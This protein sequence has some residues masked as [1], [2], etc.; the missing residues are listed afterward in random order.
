[1]ALNQIPVTNAT[2][3]PWAQLLL[4]YRAQLVSYRQQQVLINLL[5]ANVLGKLAAMVDGSDYTRLE[6]QLGLQAGQGTTLFAQ[7]NSVVG[8]FRDTDSHAAVNAAIDQFD[9]WIG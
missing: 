1:M 6:Q 5:G 8:N 9:N 2:D 4:Q 7:L 3:K